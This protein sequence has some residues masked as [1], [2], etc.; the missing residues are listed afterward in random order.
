MTTLSQEF[1]RLRETASRRKEINILAT[2]FLVSWMFVLLQGA[3]R[4]WVF[5]GVGVLYLV[6]DFPLL[7]AYLYA[8]RKGLV[9]GG[10]FVIFFFML[11]IL[12]SIHALAQVVLINHNL[13]T[14][15]IGLHHYIFYLPILF[16]LPACMNHENRQRFI[17]L[18]LWCNI[19]M[20][21][22]AII[23]SVSPGS[24]WINRTSAGDDTAFT[25]PGFLAVRSTG[26]FNF[27][28]L[29]SIW[30]GIALALALGEWLQPAELRASRSRPL[31]LI[32]TMCV[33][34]ATISSGSRTAI[35][36]GAASFLG[37]MAAVL[38]TRNYALLVRFAAVLFVLPGLAG[39]AY[40]ISPESF[41]G[42][43]S[44]FSGEEAHTEMSSRVMEMT[45]GFFTEPKFNMLGE[46]IGNGIQAAHAGSTSAYATTLSEYD[47]I[48]I[49]QEMGFVTGTLVVLLR[50]GAGIALLIAGFR[51]LGLPTGHSMPHA[52]PLAFTVVPTLMTGDI[53][54]VAPMIAA[55]IFFCVALVYGSIQFR[56]EP[57]NV[58]ASPITKM[59]YL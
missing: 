35:F 47:T 19:P 18:N 6:Q 21:V 31:L 24:A 57:L 23:Q 12:L 54:R 36:L 44:R 9:A 53:V 20:S 14:A 58:V 15:I 46:G 27:T 4:K 51:A 41:Q 13:Q 55:Q 38:M 17:R 26:T 28:L 39:V 3:L 50:Y 49:V 5:P 42:T 25:I 56:R 48:R 33:T 16:L 30:C 2:L 40:V 10:K 29:F 1:L 43:L 22:I 8:L 59:R 34:V 45:I 37:G 32:S 52:V 7:A 11:S